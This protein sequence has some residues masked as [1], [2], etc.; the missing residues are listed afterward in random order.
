MALIK[1]KVLVTGI[2]GSYWKISYINIQVMNKMI[3][4]GL[5]LY[6]DHDHAGDGQPVMGIGMTKEFR[7]PFD[8]ATYA[9]DLPAYCYA[10][11]KQQLADDPEFE[12]VVDG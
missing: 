8:Q 4:C 6:K 11:I 5:S 9:A 2:S 1:E 12:G 10:Q 7:F 3:I